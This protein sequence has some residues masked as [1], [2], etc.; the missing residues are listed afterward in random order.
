MLRKF[1]K[2]LVLALTVLFLLPSGVLAGEIKSWSDYHFESKP[3]PTGLSLIVG[4]ELT[5]Q[6]GMFPFVLNEGRYKFLSFKGDTLYGTV[7]EDYTYEIESGT[8]EKGQR[9]VLKS[10]TN[11]L[12]LPVALD[13][14]PV[15]EGYG[16]YFYTVADKDALLLVF[17]ADAKSAGDLLYTCKVS[18]L[19]DYDVRKNVN[20]DSTKSNTANSKV[21]LVNSDGAT[22]T[23]RLTFNLGNEATA[24]SFQIPELNYLMVLEDSDSNGIEFTLDNNLKNKTYSYFIESENGVK[25][26]GTFNVDFTASDNSSG[27]VEDELAEEK[28]FDKI[29]NRKPKVKITG[30]PTKAIP[31]GTPVTLTITSDIASD[32]SFNG[33]SL[34][35]S[36]KVKSAKFEVSENGVYTYSV[37]T[38]RKVLDDTVRIGFF[39]DILP[40]EDA[41]NKKL[42]TTGVG[43][44][45]DISTQKLAQ[46]GIE[47]NSQLYFILL[48]TILG[49]FIALTAV[50]SHRKGA[51]PNEEN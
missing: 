40:S 9:S 17:K 1:N 47:S 10:Y 36:K 2:L 28:A 25:Y 45:G 32:F 24:D 51:N 5:E 44:V 33:N 16:S 12:D 20:S 11:P 14:T 15:S 35:D 29:P 42:D 31:R 19:A 48:L 49:V 8:K 22:G 6:R 3:K 43:S 26:D 4:Y 23:F 50:I 18:D 13:N 41:V 38:G 34:N 46:T 7:L 27:S 30:F 21:T 37:N 39:E